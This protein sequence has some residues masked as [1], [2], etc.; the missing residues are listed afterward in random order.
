[1]PPPSANWRRKRSATARDIGGDDVLIGLRQS[2]PRRRHQPRLGHRSVEP[3][4]ADRFPA[5]AGP[6]RA[7]PLHARPHRSVAPRRHARRHRA[8]LGAAEPDARRSAL[9][10]QRRRLLRARLFAKLRRDRQRQSRH[11]LAA[12]RFRSHARTTRVST[13]CGSRIA[14]SSGT[15]MVTQQSALAEDRPPFFRRA[16]RDQLRDRVARRFRI[17]RVV[18]EFR[19]QVQSPRRT[20]PRTSARCAPQ[21]TILPSLVG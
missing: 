20:H 12:T 18:D 5:G 16:R 9:A 21:A 2:A 14:S 17:A 19:R 7:G 4:A 13:K 15:T 1:M 6:A 10:F 11:D 8:A 3:H